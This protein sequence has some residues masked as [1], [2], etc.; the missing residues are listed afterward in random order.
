MIAKMKLFQ[1]DCPCLCLFFRWLFRL[2][3]RHWA[4]VCAGCG[5]RGCARLET[6]R[7]W[8]GL[9]V[10]LFFSKGHDSKGHDNHWKAR[11]ATL[12]ATE[13]THRTRKIEQHL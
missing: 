9:C 1:G 12:L 13:G 2:K 8:R 10:F 4:E 7:C 5:R 3:K 11:A 6:G